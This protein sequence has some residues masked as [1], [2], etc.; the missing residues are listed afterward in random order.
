MDAGAVL[1]RL[2]DEADLEQ[3]QVQ[4]VAALG[5][6][7]EAAGGIAEAQPRHRAALQCLSGA[8]IDVASVEPLPPGNPLWTAPN[9]RISPHSA[10]TVARY[11]HAVWD[12]FLDNMARYR[13][14]ETLRNV[15][16]S[17]Y[18]G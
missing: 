8:A 9:I 4:Q 3:F 6:A 7:D 1:H 18:V 11:F 5:P 12:L 15:Q 2:G 14:G 16:S 13:R 17:G 10:A